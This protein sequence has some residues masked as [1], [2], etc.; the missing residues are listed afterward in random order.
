M[1]VVLLII[2][3]KDQKKNVSHTILFKINNNFSL[4]GKFDTD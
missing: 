1:K 4:N 3:S 2:A